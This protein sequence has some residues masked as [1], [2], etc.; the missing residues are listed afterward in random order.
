MLFFQCF[1]LVL[2]AIVGNFG[3]TY[4]LPCKIQYSGWLSVLLKKIAS[5]SDQAVLQCIL[6]SEVVDSK[7]EAGKKSV[8]VLHR[9]SFVY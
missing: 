1:S 6:I 7:L 3:G 4:F 5:A 8:T 2:S 9:H